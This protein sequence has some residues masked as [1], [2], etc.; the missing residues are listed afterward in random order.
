MVKD[1]YNKL[2]FTFLA[3]TPNGGSRHGLDIG[4]FAAPEFFME[5][6]DG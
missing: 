3:E 2:G 5:I 6:A 4:A 1:H